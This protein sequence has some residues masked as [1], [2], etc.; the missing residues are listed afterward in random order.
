MSFFI[1][2]EILWASRPHLHADAA[3]QGKRQGKVDRSLCCKPT[4]ESAS[5]L[6]SLSLS[7]SPSLNFLR[8]CIFQHNVS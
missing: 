1:D 5:F 6:Q 8:L 4:R 7:S 2:A 3:T